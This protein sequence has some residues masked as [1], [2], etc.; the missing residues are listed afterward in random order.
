MYLSVSEAV[1]AVRE[2]KM[3]LITDDETRENEADLCVAAQFAT[4][5]AINFFAHA[6]SGLICVALAGERLDALQIPLLES[7]NEPLQG[8][9][10]TVSVDAR[11]GTTTGI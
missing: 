3:V 1:H 9:A 10:F 4:P 7:S 6:A 2:G 11:C 5:T 8:T